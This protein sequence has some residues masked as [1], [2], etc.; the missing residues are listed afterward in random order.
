MAR[1]IELHANRTNPYARALF[2]GALG[3][4]PPPAQA[5][6]IRLVHGEV[7]AFL[8][9]EPAQGFDGFSLSNVLDGADSA[10]AGRLF[11][12]VRRAARPEAKVVLRSFAEPTSAALATNQAARDRAMLWGILDVRPAAAL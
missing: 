6:D 10:H 12:A 1:C 2:L 11:A 3:D 9:T 5:R 7:A 4:D 8:E